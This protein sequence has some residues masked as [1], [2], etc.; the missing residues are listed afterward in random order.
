MRMSREIRTVSPS[1]STAAW[2]AP[3]A[4]RIFSPCCSLLSM[5]RVSCCRSH[6]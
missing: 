4:C 5:T 3:N 1:L 2:V 6:S